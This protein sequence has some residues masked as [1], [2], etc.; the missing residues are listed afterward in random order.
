LRFHPVSN[1]RMLCYS[2]LSTDPHNLVVMVVNLDF[3]NAQ[4]GMIDLPLGELGLA[5]E[6][7]IRIEDLVGGGTF[8]WHGGNNFV[9]LDPGS[10]VGHVFR[11]TQ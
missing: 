3:Q 2:K 9:K 10:Q 11:V 5:G 1:D 4:Q 8:T 6:R 7:P